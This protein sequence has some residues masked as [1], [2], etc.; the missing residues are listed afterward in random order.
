MLSHHLPQ[1]VILDLKNANVSSIEPEPANGRDSRLLRYL[2]QYLDLLHSAG[3][4]VLFSLPQ[5]GRNTPAMEIAYSLTA[6]PTQ[7]EL[8]PSIYG[9][10]VER[11]NAH[12]SS[13]WLK[14]AMSAYGSITSNTTDQSLCCLAEFENKYEGDFFRI[15][16][17]A[18]S[19]SVLCSR[20]VVIQFDIEELKF[21]A[22]VEFT[23]DPVQEYTKWK[24][25]MVVNVLQQRGI[26]D[27]VARI[28]FDLSNGRYHHTLSAY[29]GLNNNNNNNNNAEFGYRDLIISFF[30]HHYLRILHEAGYNVL[31]EHNARWEN[32]KKQKFELPED[33]EGSWWSLEAPDRGGVSSR[34]T[35]QRAKMHGFDQVIAISQESINIQFSAQLASPSAV[36]LLS[37][38]YEEHQEKPPWQIS[39]QD[40]NLE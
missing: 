32:I 3:N 27:N 2:N 16:F 18:P 13:L 9:V 37:W 5:F 40:A 21:F 35:I 24:V 14:A 39:T 22:D 15:K 28:M 25:A 11:I 12:M 23:A 6:T 34:E 20:E 29:P 38:A 36:L 30:T 7:D 31:Y 19:V 17:G 10:T 8:L 26:D 33:V 4:H 1:L